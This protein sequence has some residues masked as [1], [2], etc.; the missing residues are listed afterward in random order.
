MICRMWM[1]SSSAMS[2][3]TTE[4]RVVAFRSAAGQHW[5]DH[6]RQKIA[7]RLMGCDQSEITL[8]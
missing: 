8:E 3:A 7:D 2:S 6:K 1:S 4:D 5:V